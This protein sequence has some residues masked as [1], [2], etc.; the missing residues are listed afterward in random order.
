MKIL[1]IAPLIERVPPKTYGGT[2]RVVHALTEQLVKRGH[3]VTLFATGDSQTCAKLVSVCDSALREQKNQNPYKPNTWTLLNIGLAYQQQEAFDIIH[4]HNNEVSLPTANLAK[5]PVVI[6][7]HGAFNPNKIRLYEELRN[8]YVVSI[9]NAQRQNAPYL[10]YIGNVYNG[11]PMQ[12]YPFSK[13]DDGYLLFV[14]RISMEKGV[15]YAIAVAKM[16]HLPLLIAAKLDAIDTPY[17]AA[18]VKPHLSKQIKWIGEV[19][20]QE[21]NM[22]MSRALCF[23]HPVT[24][25]EPFGLTLIESMSCGAPVVAFRKG[26]IPEVIKHGKTGFVVQN[27]PEMISAVKKIR[28]INRSYC[29]RYALTNFSDETMA[30]GYEAIYDTMLQEKYT[31]QQKSKENDLKKY[32]YI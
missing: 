4:D 6:T 19:N 15:H 32:L 9:S 2:E 21:R 3:D 12:D 31:F 1:Q 20:E 7:M 28:T 10:N 22:L 27:V 14:G 23:L 17:F 16:L 25:P 11:L 8:P 18:Y 24:W 5:T 13:T 26:S 30:D 29:R